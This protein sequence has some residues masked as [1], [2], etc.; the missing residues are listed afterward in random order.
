[1]SDWFFKQGGRDRVIDW[2]G[3]DSKIDSTLSDIWQR[4]SNAWNASAS[5][6]ARF[7]LTG[8]KR[9]ANEAACESLTLGAGGLIVLYALA[10]P[11]F[12]EFDEDRFLTG[13]FSVKF[14][15]QEG[16]EIGK[17]GILHNDAVP[18]EEIPESVIKATLATEDR[19]FFEH[20]GVDFLGTTR[21]LIENVRANSVVQGGSTLTQQLAKNLFLSSERSITRKIKEVFL[22]FL[23][24]SRLTKREILKLYLD[25]AYM[26][27]GAFGVEAA[28]QFYFGKSVRDVNLAEA[29]LLAGLYK[30]PT[31]FAPHVNLPRSRAR[32]N[33]VLSNLVEAGFYTAG[34]VHEARIRPAV[35]KPADNLTSPDWFLDWAFEEVKRI[36]KG[37]N[38]YVL[39]ARTT[40]DLGLQRMAEEALVSTVKNKGRYKRV[41]AGALVSME[42]DGAVR[43]VVGGTNYGQSQFN[44]AT[45]ARR[46]PGSS[47]K[48]YIYALALHKG[49]LRANSTVRDSSPS[50]G[51]W[52]PKNYN[53]SYGS[54][55]RI[56]LSYALAK[57]LNTTAV[58]LSQKLGR[59]NVAEFAKS[60]GVNG[61][62]PTCSMAL[63]DGA[64]TVMEHTGG[65]AT[66]ANGG[67]L[68]KPYAIL[69]L[70]NSRG[71]LIYSHEK[72]APKP[73]QIVPRRVAEGLN[74][75]MHQVVEAGTGGRAK[76]NFTHAV[77]KTGT[78]SSYRD[79]WFVGFTGK[80]VTG[81]WLGNDDFRPTG[82]VTGGS[83][84]AQTWQSYMS[85]AHRNMNIPT[86]P[87]L[88]TH[89]TQIAERDRL[90]ALRL[91]D[92]AFAERNL[93]PK[94]SVSLMPKQTRSALQKLAATLRKAGGL[95][96]AEAET[97]E[98]DA[99]SENTNPDER[100]D[101]RA[102]LKNRQA[103][104]R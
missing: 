101:R 86:I 26:G 44:R 61:I 46:Q 22:A 71:E 48:P 39:T 90:A 6:F 12:T 28:A 43:A 18:L 3:L 81:V 16:N 37:K 45:S 59:K 10:L 84:P 1:M 5:F 96:P 14:L 42:T 21:A 41:R 74:R 31:S 62:R 67:K 72:D 70:V 68:A 9:L 89:P 91:T 99:P 76:L 100:P 49:G 20:I 92:P 69:E 53:G 82:R 30:A 103:G 27:G 83:L 64:V 34:Q 88:R 17:R 54:G 38:E 51:R 60:L 63:G 29:A 57:S 80:F 97:D 93:A 65:F 11:A 66:F 13:Q 77:G 102:E 7:R 19:R 33:E 40:V 58:S 79:A 25:R 95:P 8:W 24:E 23:L 2:M 98:T 94:K 35:T 32:T 4:I 56:A 50:C 73:P 75:M 87:G 85:V 36:A 78:S 55:R 47:F 52:R 104:A 15:D